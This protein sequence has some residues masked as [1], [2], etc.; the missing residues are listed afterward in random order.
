MYENTVHLNAF[1]YSPSIFMRIFLIIFL[2][3]SLRI[4]LRISLTI[5]R[6]ISLQIFLRIFY[7]IFW[8]IFFI[9]MQYAGLIVAVTWRL[10]RLSTLFWVTLP[11]VYIFLRLALLS[12]MLTDSL[13]TAFSHLFVQFF[14]SDMP[15]RFLYLFAR[16]GNIF[17]KKKD[18]S[19][20]LSVDFPVFCTMLK[21][22][23][24]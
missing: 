17:L 20:R 15:G 21:F 18:Y 5:F 2:G 3:L 8:R 24:W 23:L 13:A 10:L 9:W 14:F 19:L 7:R 1:E 16:C 22:L 4:F 12:S 6:R 11:P